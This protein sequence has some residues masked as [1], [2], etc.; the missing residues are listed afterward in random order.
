[1]KKKTLFISVGIGILV[2]I[3]FAFLIVTKFGN[4]ANIQNT[5]QPSVSN[6][7]ALPTETENSKQNIQSVQ[8][9]IKNISESPVSQQA[10]D[11]GIESI[12]FKDA[13]GNKIPLTDFGKATKISIIGQLRN[14]LDNKDYD[15]YYCPA[16][17]NEKKYA[18]YFGYDVSKGQGNLYSGTLT[19]MGNWEKTMLS[20]LHAVL[21]PEV[22]FSKEELDQ[23]LEFKDGK[24]RYAEVLLPGGKISSINY[25]VS[26]N[27]V[28]IS[29][30]PSCLDKLVEIYEPLEP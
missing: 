26:L 10:I 2:L 12:G 8:T 18:I 17:G 25:H 7:T 19:W 13:Q 20:D 14:Y 30:S 21:F 24:F 22:N 1:M 27:G 11:K 3:T 4:K 15:M 6:P 28:I 5:E 23:K 16:N 29:T 9:N